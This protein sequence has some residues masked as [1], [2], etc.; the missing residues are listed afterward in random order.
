LRL[1]RRASEV[2]SRLITPAEAVAARRAMTGAARVKKRILMR[3]VWVKKELG[4]RDSRELEDD[5]Y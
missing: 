4:S 5:D 3:R 2:A 1:A